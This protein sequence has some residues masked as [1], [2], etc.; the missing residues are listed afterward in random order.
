MSGLQDE[1]PKP[2]FEGSVC[3]L[4]RAALTEYPVKEVLMK[5][6]NISESAIKTNGKGISQ[7]T[8]HNNQ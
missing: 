5:E 3:A 1:E 2:I 8:I 4:Q 6:Y 7:P